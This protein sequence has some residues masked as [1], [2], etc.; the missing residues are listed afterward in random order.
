[1][2]YRA[3]LA[4][5]GYSVFLLEAGGDSSGDILEL[6]PL[7]SAQA[8]ETPGHSWQFFV[9]H[10]QNE[11]QARRDP[12]YTYIQ[13]NGSYYHGLNPLKMQCRATLGGSA[14]VNAMN[15]AW[16]PDNEWDYIANL[17]GDESW[18]H[19]HL[20]RHLMD[21]ENCTYVPRGTPGH[22]FDGYIES[23]HGNTTNGL[24]SDNAA[25][26]VAEM[27]RQA[28]GIEVDGVEHMAELLH[29]DINGIEKDRYEDPLLFIVPAAVSPSN[30][31]RSGVA[32]YINE[33]VAAGHPLTVSLHSLATRVLLEQYRDGKKPKAYGV[34]YMVGEGLYSADQRYNASQ[35][36]KIRTVRA[37]KEVIVSG[38]S[39]NTPQIL[40]L[41]GIGP[42][43]E[44]ENLGIPVLIDLPAVGNFMQDNYEV[45][46]H[47]RAEEPWLEAINFPCT[48]RFDESDPCFVLWQTNRTGPYAER[49]G[50]FTMTWRSSFSWNNDTD[51]FFLSTAGFGG[52]AGFYPGYSNRTV[53]PH[54]WNTPIV[55]MQTSNA[56]GTVTLR[57]TDPR[58]APDINLNYFSQRA[59]EDL[60]SLI[61]GIELML[62][63]YDEVGIPYR[64]LTPD[65]AID[66]KQSIMDV[67]FSH[68][69]TSSCRMGPAGHKDYCV[70]SKFRVNGVDKLRV[71]DASVLPRT[72][73]AMPNGPTF[74]ISRKAYETILEDN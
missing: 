15:F 71:V 47:V 58:Q 41:S 28:E 48:L 32:G 42:R 26:F 5:S 7:L 22:G 49:G 6:L 25:S 72:P 4:V 21:L 37:K 54:D 69:A 2:D 59:E 45:P 18:S 50:T 34:E 40:K 56:A 19:Q 14:Q 29:R 44:L 8:A 13:S 53:M 70:D 66:M 51:L 1:M 52:L 9:E 31:G 17:T 67:A 27:F 33:V 61:E 74:T 68:H 64:V 57:S 23:S 43:E 39:F 46:T 36:D 11:T 20:R 16:A 60:Q 55:K 63:V 30:G 65:P 35:T 24:T 62:S 38:G 12:K 10:Y 3:N 73:G